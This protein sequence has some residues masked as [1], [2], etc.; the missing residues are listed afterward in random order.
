[1]INGVKNKSQLAGVPI[2]APTSQIAVLP[3]VSQNTRAVDHREMLAQLED[4]LTAKYDKLFIPTD[5]P[6][7]MKLRNRIINQNNPGPFVSTDSDYSTDVLAFTSMAESAKPGDLKIQVLSHDGFSLDMH[8][9][10]GSGSEAESR[11]VVGFGSILLNR[12]LVHAHPTGC[13]VRGYKKVSDPLPTPAAPISTAA[14]TAVPFSSSSIPGNTSKTQSPDPHSATPRVSPKESVVP[15]STGAVAG[16]THT[17][18]STATR[19]GEVTRINNVV[20]K[21]VPASKNHF[22]KLMKDWEKAYED[23]HGHSPNPKEILKDPVGRKLFQQIKK[24]ST[25][26][27]SPVPTDPIASSSES[28]SLSNLS[29]VSSP[30]PTPA[31]AAGLA[32]NAKLVK[33]LVDWEIA[34]KQQHGHAPSPQDMMRNPVGRQLF[35]GIKSAP[36][37]D[38]S[39]YTPESSSVQIS[40][41][42]SVPA[43]TASTTAAVTITASDISVHE[44]LCSPPRIIQQSSSRKQKVDLQ[45]LAELENN[46]LVR[47]KH[48]NVSASKIRGNPEM[49][50]LIAVLKR[51]RQQQHEGDSNAFFTPQLRVTIQ[52]LVQLENSLIDKYAIS[53]P[54]ANLK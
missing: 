29:S 53:I 24:L 51:R 11:V 40:S 10:I 52:D 25:G 50:K 9:V 36:I 49:K 2:L 12:P 14:T 17:N 41:S 20:H 22:L 3:A 13:A 8:V 4:R 6:E 54:G 35:E 26:D 39:Q 28:T 44:W 43:A 31:P 16:T 47:Y 23:Q 33:L 46:L 45:V 18:A 27:V 30:G 5:H 7:L 42:V 37:Q 32:S 21:L 34:Y 19:L 48:E 15:K 1:M 38:A